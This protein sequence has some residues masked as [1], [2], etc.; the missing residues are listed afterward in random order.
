M[1]R[2]EPLLHAAAG[3]DAGCSLRTDRSGARF[4]ARALGLLSFGLALGAALRPGV[5][6]AAFPAA[7]GWQALRVVQSRSPVS[8]IRIWIRLVKML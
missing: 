7:A 8:A 1:K 2:P 3:Q 5:S 6:A 4:F